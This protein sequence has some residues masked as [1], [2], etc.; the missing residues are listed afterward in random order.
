M[1][2][3]D[4]CTKRGVLI[5]AK[6]LPPDI[7]FRLFG[8]TSISVRRWQATEHYINILGIHRNYRRRQVLS[9]ELLRMV[10]KKQIRVR[11]RKTT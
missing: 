6:E 8:I 11:K 1:A 9:K 3:Y 5:L 4:F 2:P 10:D 7:L